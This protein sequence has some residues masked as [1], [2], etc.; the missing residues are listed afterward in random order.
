MA[1]LVISTAMAVPYME[2]ML[3]GNQLTAAADLVKSRLTDMR[4]RAREEGRAYKL[5]LGDNG[6]TFRVE[7]LTEEGDLPNMVSEE[8]LPKDISFRLQ[9]CKSFTTGDGSREEANTMELIVLPDG[10]APNDYEISFG[11]NEGP[12]LVV[13]LKGQTG[14]VS[15]KSNGEGGR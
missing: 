12:G 4:S 5:T 9:E 13:C 14:A 3:A 2:G 6:A 11:G 10:T 7:P 8:Q 1:I 15:T